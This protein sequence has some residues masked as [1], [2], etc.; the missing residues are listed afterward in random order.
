MKMYHF[1]NTAE[2]GLVQYL[3]KCARD[4][5]TNG[6]IDCTTDRVLKS[7]QVFSLKDDIELYPGVHFVR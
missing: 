5:G 6:I 1:Q 7:L 2:N 3:A 4:N